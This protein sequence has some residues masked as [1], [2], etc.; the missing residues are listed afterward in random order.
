MATKVF[1]QY[2]D[3]SQAALASVFGCPQNQDVY[4]N[5]DQIPSSDARYGM[6]F[7]NLPVLV[8]AHLIRPGD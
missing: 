3:A 4:P 5:Q 7:T 6:Y 2:S 8:Q 1:V